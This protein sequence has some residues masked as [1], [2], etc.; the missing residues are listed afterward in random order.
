MTPIM[1]VLF[2]TLGYVKVYIPLKEYGR[3]GMGGAGMGGMEELITQSPN[4]Y[5]SNK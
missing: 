4:H 1:V 5:L 3:V 2:L